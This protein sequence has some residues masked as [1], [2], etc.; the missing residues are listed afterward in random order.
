M[1]VA[2]FVTVIV[3]AGLLMIF[4]FG[5]IS[6]NV[7]REYSEKSN[8]LDFFVVLFCVLLVVLAVVEFGNREKSNKR[9][10]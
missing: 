4:R 3:L 5:E 10:R 8:G 6:A 9:K 1:I 2:L 7:V